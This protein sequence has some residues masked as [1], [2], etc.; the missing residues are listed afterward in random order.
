MPET[1]LRAA[2]ADR[3]TVAEVLGT[4]LREGRLTV[5]EYDERLAATYAARTHTDLAVLTA[6][7]P[8]PASAS[9]SASASAPASAPGPATR[10]AHGSCGA[11]GDL[12]TAWRGWITVALIVCSVYLA[13]TIG[14]G[15][16]HYP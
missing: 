9:E 3:A 1:P 7:L 11:G 6:D 5:A 13:T 2:D 4:A 8:A 16:W 12:R 15:E 14:T 10:A